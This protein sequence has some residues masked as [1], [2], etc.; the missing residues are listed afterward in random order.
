MMKEAIT[1]QKQ[2]KQ[3]FALKYIIE[4]FT[5]DRNMPS[6]HPWVC[7]VDYG[8]PVYAIWFIS[9]KDVYYIIWLSDILI[10]MKVI[11]ETCRVY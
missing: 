11:L 5:C 4:P 9:H 2:K 7:L 10:I 1:W 6:S 3:L 8:Y